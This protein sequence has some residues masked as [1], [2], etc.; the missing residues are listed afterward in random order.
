MCIVIDVERAYVSSCSFL[1]FRHALLLAPSVFPMQ[2][3][4]QPNERERE[5]ERK[6][7][8]RTAKMVVYATINFNICQLKNLWKP[9]DESVLSARCVVLRFVSFRLCLR[10]TKHMCSVALKEK[11][12]CVYYFYNKKKRRKK[13]KENSE[14]A[15]VCWYL[16]P[17]F[18]CV[19]SAAGK[20]ISCTIS[21]VKTVVFRWPSNVTHIR[22]YL[23]ANLNLSALQV[24]NRFAQFRSMGEDFHSFFFLL[25]TA[26][27]YF[28]KWI[29]LEKMSIILT[30]EWK[31]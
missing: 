31:Y 6:C 20:L 2:I 30:S 25:V 9:N 28:W 13:N 5:W 12:K 19:A 27:Q 4:S 3:H 15:N 16:H 26:A 8:K 7:W 10:N 11:W 18:R 21:E 29:K 24:T 22:S 14:D 1:L 23:S 17:I